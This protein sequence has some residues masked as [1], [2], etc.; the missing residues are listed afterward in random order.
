MKGRRGSRDSF[1][2]ALSSF[3]MEVRKF[4]KDIQAALTKD[5]ERS[6]KKGS[7][8]KEDALLLFSKGVGFEDTGNLEK[9][10]AHYKKA[11]KIDPK[12]QQAQAKLEDLG[13]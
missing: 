11:L 6:L 2:V 7:K 1:T 5:E 8:V 12:F 9:A 3:P 13:Y 4:L 10:A